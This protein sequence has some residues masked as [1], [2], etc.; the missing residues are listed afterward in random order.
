MR[1]LLPNTE[2]AR[3]TKSAKPAGRT[4]P[5]GRTG[6]AGITGLILSVLCLGVMS[7]CT[8]DAFQ[9]EWRAYAGDHAS[10]KYAPLAVIDRHNVMDLEV[11]W[12]WDSIDNA[13]LEADSTLRVFVNEATPLKVGGVLYTSTALSQVAAIDA[14]TGETIWSYDPETWKDGTPANVGFVHRG[15]AYWEDGE[16]R[17]ILYA[18]GDAWLI[19]LDAG[20]GEPVPGFGDNGRVDLTKGLRR[21]VDRSLY[22]VSSPP[23]IVRGVVVV[24]ATVLDSFAVDRM[25]DA[26]MP[27]GDV[28]GFDVRTGEQ[29][30]VFQTI[31]QEG[32]YGN[33]T[34][35]DESWKTAGSTNVWTWMSADEELGYVYLPVSTPTNDFYGGHRLGDNLFAESLVCVNAET[36]ER[37]WHF[38][39]VHHGI[40]DYDLPAAPILVDITVDGRE[41]KA[42]VQ[43]TKQGFT[44]VF[45]RV[46]GEPVWPIEERETPPTTVPGETASPTQPFPTKPAA[47]ER[48]G[49]TE[50]DL[51]DFTPELRQAA[52]D[53]IAEYDHG[54]LFTPPTTRGVIAVPGLVGGASWSG[55]AVNPETGMLYVPSYS[56]PAIMTV[57][58][59]E[60]EDAPYSYTGRFAYGPTVM[61]GL[62][63]IKPPYGRITAIDLNTGEH[64][65]MSPVGSGPRN[66]PAL[67]GL[68]LP[69]LGWDRRTFPLLTQTLLFAAQMGIVLDREVSD[70]GNAMTYDSESNEAFL[71]AFDP[72]TGDLIAEIPLPGNA[73]GNPMTYMMGGKQYIAVPIGGASERAE[74]VALGLP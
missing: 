23:A 60:A 45:D 34:W 54:P 29:K 66:H 49:L 65:W 69:A 4:G 25:P 10:T 33:E 38:Q 61:D 56:L 31:P 41:I 42:A 68:D 19:A 28:R 43:V 71:R 59:S 3:M 73:T 64:V 8:S 17:R 18:T 67:E 35:L 27:P 36:G 37:V 40:W 55:A 70:R 11:A 44:F 21:P 6:L 48:Q 7:S 58:E 50:D 5:V 1:E 2:L 52:L 20:T 13:I 16:D 62:P 24:G 22:A 9:V 12:R 26:A 63:V 53:A 72:D 39:A 46:T 30:W 74:L 15:V 32:E 51:I 14:A 57:N 47:F